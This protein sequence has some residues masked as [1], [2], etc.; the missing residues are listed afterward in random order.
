MI[1]K[2][3]NAELVIRFGS[4]VRVQVAFYDFIFQ[5]ALEL[6]PSHVTEALIAGFAD[7]EDPYENAVKAI[8]SKFNSF[9]EAWTA[10]KRYHK[11]HNHE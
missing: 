1:E 2:M 4:W 5:Q 6:C 8:E 7:G 11:E 10:F 9:K 3:D